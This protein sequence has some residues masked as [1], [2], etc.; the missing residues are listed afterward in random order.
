MFSSTSNLIVIPWVGIKPTYQKQ[1]VIS[2]LAKNI[3]HQKPV[4]WR[5]NFVSGNN[6]AFF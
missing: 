3:L 2:L 4:S 1:Q 5:E 6:I